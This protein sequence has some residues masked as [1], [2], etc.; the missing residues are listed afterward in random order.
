ME[1][2]TPANENLEHLQRVAKYR[3]EVM[4]GRGDAVPPPQPRWDPKKPFTFVNATLV[5]RLEDLE[6]GQREIHTRM[7]T[8][9]FDSRKG[10][11]VKI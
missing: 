11:C 5:E 7:N 3:M 2:H 9:E 10:N 8:L 6:R 4:E 1:P